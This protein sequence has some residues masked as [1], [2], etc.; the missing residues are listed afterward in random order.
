M[1]DIIRAQE[2]SRDL[3]ETFH[4]LLDRAEDPFSLVADY[5]G[6]GVFKKLTVITDTDKSLPTPTKFEEPKLNYGPGAEARLR[7]NE[8]KSSISG[9]YIYDL[10]TCFLKVNYIMAITKVDMILPVGKTE[11]RR[12]GYDVPTLI[13]EERYRNFAKPDVYSSSL[14]ANIS[15]TGSGLSTPRGNSAKASPVPIREARILNST[16]PKSSPIEKSFVPPKNPIVPSNPFETDDYDESKNPFA[17][18]DDD[19]ANN[20]FKD[21]DDNDNDADNDD[22]DYNRNL[23]PFGR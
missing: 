9:F 20:P 2:Q 21:D 16:T 4:S 17:N 1:L 14:E 12:A 10:I 5:F 7:L 15:G 23:N 22:D 18:D 19:D 11:A 3:H 13:T 6:R 8:G